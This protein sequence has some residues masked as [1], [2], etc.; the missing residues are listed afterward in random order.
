VLRFAAEDYVTIH[1]EAATTLVFLEEDRGGDSTDSAAD[2]DE[3]VDLADVSCVGDSLFESA[4]A[5]RVSALR[6]S[7]VQPL[8]W[9]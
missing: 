8:E 1:D 5:H 4:I 2:G 6:T 3:G 9:A 7:Q